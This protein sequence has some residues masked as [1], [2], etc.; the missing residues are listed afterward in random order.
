MRQQGFGSYFDTKRMH[1]IMRRVH[2]THLYVHCIRIHTC[3]V[4][5]REQ[6]RDQRFPVNG[7][8]LFHSSIHSQFFSADSELNALRKMQEREKDTRV[9][10]GLTL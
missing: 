2:R 8:A 7:N 6:R 10:V 9:H 3:S 1:L 4:T 5:E